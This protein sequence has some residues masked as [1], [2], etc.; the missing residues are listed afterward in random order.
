MQKIIYRLLAV[1]IVWGCCCG[2]HAIAFPMQSASPDVAEDS[3][4]VRQS[5]MQFDP[6]DAR[7]GM[8]RVINDVI[9]PG[10]RLQVRPLEDRD[11]P[12]IVRIVSTTPH[13][14]GFRY[15]ME[16]YALEEG[17]Y[18]VADYLETD[19]GESTPIALPYMIV[20]VSATLPDGQI[21]PTPLDSG[22]VPYTGGYRF[23]VVTAILLWILGLIALIFVGRTRRVRDTPSVVE[24]IP[25]RQRLNELISA[26]RRGE[27]DAQ[28]NAGLERA[29]LA[30]WRDRLNL[31]HLD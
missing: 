21:M 26:A 29:V 9:L 3:Q 4:S 15:A 2:S 20:N 28:Q 16:F 10:P 12:F 23:W 25:P 7:I 30:I 11:D 19:S 17:T 6:V 8:P 14:E 18:N 13:G 1:W 5:T 24:E 27:L 31:R 22:R